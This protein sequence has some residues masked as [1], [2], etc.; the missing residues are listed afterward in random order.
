M[1]CRLPVIGSHIGRLTDYIID[2]VNGFYFEPN[3]AKDL[4]DKI[5]LYYTQSYEKAKFNER[6]CL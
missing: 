1:A 5:Y 2:K 6:K 3:N 4:A